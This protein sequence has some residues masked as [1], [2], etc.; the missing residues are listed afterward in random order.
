LLVFFGI[1]IAI[2]AMKVRNPKTLWSEKAGTSYG[3]S[4]AWI[5]NSMTLDAFN[6][7]R[8]FLRFTDPEQTCYDKS[9]PLRKV[10]PALTHF[11]K[12]FRAAYTLGQMLVVD[13]AMIQYAGRFVNFV[14]YMPLKPISHGIKEYVLCCAYTGYCYSFETYTGP[15]ADVDGSAVGVITRLFE[16]ANMESTGAGRVLITDSYYTGLPLMEHCWLSYS[17]F[18]VGTY[19]LSKKVSR[20]ATDF[21]FHKLSP[22][23]LRSVRR[24]WMR[25][26]VR[27]VQVRGAAVRSMVI[28]AL[29]WKDKKEVAIWSNYLIEPAA[30]TDIVLR[31]TRGKPQ[32]EIQTHAIVK[33]YQRYMN[34]VDRSDRDTADWGINV[35]TGRWY[36]KVFFWAFSKALANMFVIST[37][38]GKDNPSSA[39]H[40]YTTGS[41][42]R[43]RWQMDLAQAL[44]AEGVR[45]GHVDAEGERPAWMRKTY[46]PCDCGSCHTCVT[47]KTS[48]VCHPVSCHTPM[49]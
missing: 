31:R 37:M 13:E 7:H 33:L 15:S 16:G 28:Q 42:R 46:L 4:V 11:A 38:I 22:A 17:M 24:G 25:R 12:A 32:A 41:D 44:V 18:V 30:T 26:A 45:L 2:A 19:S 48:G 49:L 47:G 9:D 3:T 36:L 14:Q 6:A 29:V 20:V 5:R 23:A 39:F 35:R 27:T 43:Y 40:K 1:M 8:Q 10:R 34:G 21:P